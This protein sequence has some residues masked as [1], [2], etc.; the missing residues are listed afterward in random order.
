M[1]QGWPTYRTTHLHAYLPYHT[2]HL[3]AYLP[4]TGGEMHMVNE[5]RPMLEVPSRRHCH[6]ILTH[7]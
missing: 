1:L 5:N 4:K 6:E 2:T 3:H 7:L